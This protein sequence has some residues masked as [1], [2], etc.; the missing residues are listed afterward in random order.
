MAELT[1]RLELELRVGWGAALALEPAL[2]TLVPARHR[3]GA[4]P[5]L[6][7]RAQNAH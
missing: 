5:A 1:F 6:Q 2:R 7:N 4:E 3:G